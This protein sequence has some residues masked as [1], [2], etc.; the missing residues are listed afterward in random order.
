MSA[1]M[2]SLLVVVLAVL[3]VA[4]EARN[5]KTTS[6][7]A[8]SNKDAVL[9]P[10][11]FPPFDRLPGSASPAFGGMPGAG[12]S[13]PGFSLPG[14]GGGAT[15]GFGSIGSMPFL[16]GSSLPGIGGGSSLPGM[17]GVGGMPG[18][19]AAGAVVERANKP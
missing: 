3:A 11:T 13:I 9:Q 5:L 19:P 1:K 15:P 10:T 17:G 14:S 16:G 4:T 2:V 12:S 18:S 7:A 6:E 8:S